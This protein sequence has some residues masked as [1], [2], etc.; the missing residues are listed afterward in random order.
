MVKGMQLEKSSSTRDEILYILKTKISL[1]VSEIAKKMGIT[2][3]AVRRHLNTLERDQYVQT[4]LVRQAMGRPTHEYSLTE[5]GHEL[6]P[7]NYAD[8]T[9]DFLKGIEELEG[10]KMIDTLFERREARLEETYRD[11]MKGLS[12]EER[13]KALAAIQ[14]DKGYMVRWERINDGEFK[15]KEYNC[16]ISQVAKIYNKACNCELSLFQKLLGTKQIERTECLAKGGD[17]CVYMIKEK[18]AVD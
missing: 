16:P 7:K 8:I 11:Q 18:G 9:M 2:E 10:H 17:H 1:P 13:V 5:K 3:M 12:F 4:Q 6:F 15:L 14:N